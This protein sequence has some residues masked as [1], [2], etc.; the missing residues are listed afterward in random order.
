MKKHRQSKAQAMF[1]RIA[2]YLA[3][4]GFC[5]FFALYM[6]AY[7]GWIFF[8]T[9][10]AAPVF[11]ALITLAVNFG[12]KVE[13]SAETS[14]NTVCKNEEF[15]FRIKIKNKSIFP[16]SAVIIR[17]TECEGFSITG[18]A[19]YTAGVSPR[20][21]TEFEVK[22]KAEMWGP[23]QIGIESVRMEDFL[24]FFSLPIYKETGE[25]LYS[26]KIKVFPDI[27]DVPSDMPLIRSAAETIRFSDESEDTKENDGLN[28]FG[29]MPGYTHREYSE[30]DPVRRIN[31]KL[32]S[33]K[34]VYMVRLD[35]EIEAMQQMIVLDS[36][37]SSRALNERAVEGVLA[38][39]FSLF[40][41]GFESTVWYNSKD[42]FVPFDITDRGDISA[43]QTAFAE[44]SF[45]P[46]EKAAARIPR[47][48][49]AE[50]G[51]SGGIMLFTPC[52]DAALSAEAEELRQSGTEVT[53]VIAG[54][55]GVL[56]PPYWMIGSDFTAELIS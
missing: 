29:G 6:S 2:G 11:S 55:S 13:I 52:P 49:L 30:G 43:L 40:R 26:E 38:V 4:M 37:G 17:L 33:K 24:H 21:E 50:R 34:D 19:E 35:D 14:G 8:M 39:A 10:A 18:G 23:A 54:E 16:V 15:S 22:F 42:G 9:L 28:L 41:L 27:P 25:H 53:A 46:P 48:E 36:A 44:Y 47:S 5:L 7:T 1:L 31:W 20:S 56:E 12:K 51:K 45:L 32:S 3:A